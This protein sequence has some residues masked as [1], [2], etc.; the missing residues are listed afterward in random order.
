MHK[1]TV[2][3]NFQGTSKAD[4][5]CIQQL[6]A[7]QKNYTN[8]YIS[9]CVLLVL[10]ACIPAGHWFILTEAYAKFNNVCLKGLR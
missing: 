8:T 7:A 1:A 5:R 3:I 6:S 9:N 10:S 2:N 4:H